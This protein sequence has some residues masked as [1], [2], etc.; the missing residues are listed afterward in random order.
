[1]SDLRTIEVALPNRAYPIHVG[2]GVLDRLADLVAPPPRA[3]AVALITDANVA[4]LHG[5]RVND[6]L[7]R[8]D[9]R[10]EQLTLEPGEAVKTPA[11]L[12]A[13]WRWMAGVGVHRGDVVVACGGGVVG[14]LAGFAAATFHRGV[15][16]VQVPT[17][18]LAQV[19]AAIGG[20]TAVDLP[21]GK[22]LVGAFHQPRA[23]IAD[24]ELL[25]T[26]PDDEFATGMAEVIK[27][28]LIADA[29][30]LSLVRDEAE[31]IVGRDLSTLSRVVADAAAVKAEVVAQDEKESGP[32][33]HL[34]Y[35]HTLGHALETLA[36]Y[37]ALPHGR[38]VAIGM[39]FAA[40]LAV[41]LGHPDRTR[42]HRELLEAYGL[43]TGGVAHDL[44]DVLEVM[45]RD[46]K[47]DEGLRFVVLEDL[48]RPTLVSNVPET[49]LRKAF[50][51]VRA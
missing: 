17:S 2:A 24:P 32:R 5:D 21:E 25:A 31:T 48:G 42:E 3:E 18:L 40:A 33:A 15:E 9:L 11:S 49:A 36:G 34:N 29:D 44:D 8:W 6:A 38:A 28:G 22:N 47:Y 45:A 41:E 16:V 19:D 27:H 46:K 7:A 35:G 39:M 12:T 30:L 20:K 37:D 51:A 1:V 4:A 50:E 43:P 23:V 10:V 14:D 26:L 13:I